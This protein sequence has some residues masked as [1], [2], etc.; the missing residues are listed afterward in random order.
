[1]KIVAWNGYIPEK[2]KERTLA[3]ITIYNHMVYTIFTQVN[4][5]AYGRKLDDY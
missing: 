5:F 1:M 4:G 3:I 2:A